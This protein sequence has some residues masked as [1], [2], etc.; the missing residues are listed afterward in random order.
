[1]RKFSSGSTGGRRGLSRRKLLKKVLSTKA[2]Q[3][4]SEFILKCFTAL[5][6]PAAATETK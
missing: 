3:E 4:E 1:M 5:P 2:R 6:A